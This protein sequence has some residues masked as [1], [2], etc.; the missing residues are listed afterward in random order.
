M[1]NYPRKHEELR[2]QLQRVHLPTPIPTKGLL[3]RPDRRGRDWPQEGP[4]EGFMLKKGFTRTELGLILI[5][6]RTQRLSICKFTWLSQG[7]SDLVEEEELVV[8]RKIRPHC[9]RPRPTPGGAWNSATHR[10]HWVGGRLRQGPGA[11]AD[12]F[13]D[14]DTDQRVAMK[15]FGAS[16]FITTSSTRTN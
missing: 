1:V 13:R 11:L 15:K 7:R 2:E 12:E 3:R 4:R 9:S 14:V 8:V 10:R 16:P 5:W 6:M